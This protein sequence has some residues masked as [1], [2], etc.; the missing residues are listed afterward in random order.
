MNSLFI[1]AV[2]AA[3]NL[4]T[5]LAP[6]VVEASPLDQTSADIPAQV[7]IF[8]RAAIAESGAG[9][10]PQLLSR[11]RGMNIY[12]LGAGNPALAQIQMRGWGENGFGRV[13]LLSDGE[14][15]NS[16]DMTAPNYA[17]IALHAADR[18]EVLYG[19]QSVLYGDGASAGMINVI[20]GFSDPDPHGYAVLRG[21]SYGALSA[22]TGGGGGT[23]DGVDTYRFDS[24]W[25]R[26][27]GYRNRSGYEIWNVQGGVKRDFINGSHL[28]LNSF[29]NDTAYDLPGPLS[30]YDAFHNPEKSTYPDDRAR[31]RAYGFALSGK[32]VINDDNRVEGAYTLSRRESHYTCGDFTAPYGVPTA[33]RRDYRSDIWS[34]RLDPR[35]VNTSR[36]FG[37]DNRF[38]SGAAVRWDRMR[39]S[40]EERYPDFGIETGGKYIRDR[41][42]GGIFIYDELAVL[43]EVSLIAGA[44]VERMWNRDRST[45]AGYSRADDLNAFEA[46]VNY[47]PDD[48]TKIFLRWSRHYRCPFLDE[49]R[50]RDLAP[51]RTATPER[52]YTVELGAERKIAEEWFFSAVAYYSEIDNEIH[53][54]PFLLSN[55][56]S[57]WTHRRFGAELAAGW[58]RDRCAGWKIS[59]N[60]ADARKAQGKFDHNWVP[61]VPR[62][63]LNAEAKV[64]LWDEFTVCFGYRLL[65]A[66][67]AVSDTPNANGRLPSEHIFRTGCRY[68]PEWKPLNGFTFSFDCDNLFDRR[69]CDYAVA[70]VTGGYNYFYPAL[71][72]SFMFSVRYDF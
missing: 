34:M 51:E 37:L 33:Y 20:S 35:F 7:E 71:G 45:G 17:R 60:G 53:L 15:I 66:R 61:G 30:R 2:T 28:K 11:A 46:A 57:P 3:T 18:I 16:P 54:N 31:I 13:L 70:S 41:L 36:I 10:L 24:S 6:V 23:D 55:E 43:D 42:T 32:G 29:W 48:D 9:D 72:R 65:G 4:A 58:E 50:Y 40:A 49:Y 38:L 27:D 12:N 8:S 69:Y 1:L 21:G 14:Q 25:S 64:W 19:P 68:R 63:Q 67:Y 52:G 56:N 59:W 47:R 44:R 5:R 22:A 39:G 26:S 62:Q